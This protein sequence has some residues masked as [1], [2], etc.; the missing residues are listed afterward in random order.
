MNYIT[1]KDKRLVKEH[2]NRYV[3]ADGQKEL[4]LEAYKRAT[5]WAEGMTLAEIA[6]EEGVSQATV[7]KTVRLVVAKIKAFAL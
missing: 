1:S 5:M 7:S 2:L 4:S 6:A 3:Q